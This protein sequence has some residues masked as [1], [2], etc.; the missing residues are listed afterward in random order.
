MR[1]G[2][3]EKAKKRRPTQVAFTIYVEAC[4]GIANMFKLHFAAFDPST[5]NGFCCFKVGR[6]NFSL[7]VVNFQDN[8]NVVQSKSPL[9]KL[10]IMWDPFLNGYPS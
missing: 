10:R 8:F 5:W 4:V 3:L 1:C 2:T 6:F 9:A 7:G